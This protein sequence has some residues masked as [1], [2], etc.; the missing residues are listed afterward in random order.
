[1][2][3]SN[4][5]LLTLAL[6]VAIL[7]LQPIISHAFTLIELPI[8]VT[9]EPGEEYSQG[10]YPF[11]FPNTGFTIANPDQTEVNIEGASKF[12]PFGRLPGEN[13][14]DGFALLDSTLLLQLTAT[15]TMGARADIRTTYRMDIAPRRLRRSYLEGLL[16]DEGVFS[17]AGRAQ[18]RA[19]AMD[20]ADA[21]IMRFDES[22]ARWIR[23]VRA[24]RAEPIDNID[25]RFTPR[26]EPDG[27]L[28]HYGNYTDVSGNAYVWA[29]M[30]R[31]SRYAVGF[32]IDR[33]DDGLANSD[34]NCVDVTNSDQK[35]SDDDSLGDACD[36]DDDN[37]TVLDADDN[38]PLIFNHDQI[39]TDGDG[40]GDICD[41]D[42]D[43]DGVNDGSDQCLET[44][45]PAAVDMYGCSI[46]DTCPCDNAWKNHGAYVR[47][48]AHTSES[49]LNKGLISELEKDAIMSLAGQSECGSRK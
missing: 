13:I 32:T 25:F 6:A 29:V 26:M 16:L 39:D 30:D 17:D 19:R 12:I 31:N 10:F 2:S 22:G 49:F 24:I 37:D 21:R 18:V 40:F 14:Q 9:L 28:G 48:N 44:R 47:C 43:N 3:I 11:E 23:A 42:D 20:L 35:N 45:Y 15:D 7:L 1:M 34:D 4:K 27:I 33:D 36:S 38:C 46:E 41:A 8:T 5:L